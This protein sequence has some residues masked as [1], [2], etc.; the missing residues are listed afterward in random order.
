VR[1]TVARLAERWRAPLGVGVER[2]EQELEAFVFCPECAERK[3]DNEGRFDS[4]AAA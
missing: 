1:P 2:R 3:L 4:C